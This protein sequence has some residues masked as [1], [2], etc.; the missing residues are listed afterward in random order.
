MRDAKGGLAQLTKFIEYLAQV[1]KCV[2]RLDG[3]N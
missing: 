3:H 1:V 2:D